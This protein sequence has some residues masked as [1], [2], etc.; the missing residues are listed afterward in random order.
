MKRLAP[1]VRTLGNA[2]DIGEA[3][4]SVSHR[5]CP[6]RDCGISLLAS[7][8][9]S[10]L[11]MSAPSFIWLPPWYAALDR[12]PNQWGLGEEGCLILDLNFQTM[13]K[14]NPVTLQS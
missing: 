14:T 1:Q 8:T 9:A 10:N 7:Q 5:S 3:G 11:K 6:S 12:G 4:P 13:S 2:V